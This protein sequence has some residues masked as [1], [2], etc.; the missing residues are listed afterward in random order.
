MNLKKGQAKNE[1]IKVAFLNQFYSIDQRIFF[2]CEAL[3]IKGL[4]LYMRCGKIQFQNF[5]NIK[6]GNQGENFSLF[7][8]NL[9]DFYLFL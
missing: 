9:I 7:Y 4:I 2:I 1:T 5:K 6:R 8:K 3:K